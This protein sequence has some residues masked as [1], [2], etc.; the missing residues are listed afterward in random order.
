MMH[1]REMEVSV[2]WVM[3]YA[4]ASSDNSA[5]GRGLD[6]GLVAGLAGWRLGRKDV[7]ESCTVRRES[8]E[9]EA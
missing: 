9:P 3:A 8:S 7:F 2:R 5:F 6:V 4:A 1:R